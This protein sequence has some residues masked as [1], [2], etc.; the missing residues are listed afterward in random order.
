[1]N[2]GALENDRGYFRDERK[3]GNIIYPRFKS[4]GVTASSISYNC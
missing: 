1:M 2:L 4:Q 3:P